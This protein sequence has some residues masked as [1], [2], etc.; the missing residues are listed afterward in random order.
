MLNIPVPVS[1]S[2][3]I[4]SVGYVSST[5][6]DCDSSNIEYALIPNQPYQKFMIYRT[7]GTLLFIKDSVQTNYCYGCFGGS[8][9]IHPIV[10][11]P[12]KA[13]LYLRGG[14]PGFYQVHVYG[15][16]DSLPVSYMGVS[17]TDSYVEVFPNP[18]AI[19]VNF[20]ISAPDNYEQYELT[21]FDSE[22]KTIKTNAI[23]GQTTVTLDCNL[24]SSGTY[25]YSLQNK[26]NVLQT[27]K[28]IL[29]K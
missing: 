4:Y 27:G 28:F 5:L 13:K 2:G 8:V 7:D 19:Q 26:H 25:F 11:T 24:L 10:N 20:K 3:D 12:D 9:E 29:T 18:S 15:L 23:N 21:I 6:F 14:M 22:F 17:R 16:C 1:D